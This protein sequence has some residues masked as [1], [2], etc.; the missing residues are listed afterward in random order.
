MLRFNILSNTLNLSY[1]ITIICHCF[2]T[3]VNREITI[4][5]I[6]FTFQLYVSHPL[7]GFDKIII[8]IFK[9]LLLS[10]RCKLLYAGKQ[11]N[12]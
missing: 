10:F 12:N 11:S 4:F 2:I 3:L 7:P 9:G 1:K 6:E 8:E 5:S